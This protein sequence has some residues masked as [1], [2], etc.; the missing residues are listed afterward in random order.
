MSGGE[1]QTAAQS[2]LENLDAYRELVGHVMHVDARLEE[3]DG[4]LDPCT[5]RGEDGLPEPSRGVHDDR[6]VT[7]NRQRHDLGVAR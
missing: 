4:V 2:L 1:A 7:E 6:V 5:G 3:I